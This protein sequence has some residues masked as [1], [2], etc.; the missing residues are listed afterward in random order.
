MTFLSEAI[1]VLAV[2]MTLSRVSKFEVTANRLKTAVELEFEG[3]DDL[4][5][6]LKLDQKK[7]HM[8][9]KGTFVSVQ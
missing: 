8:R 3:I 2:Q 6:H 1:R 5:N 4:R 7:I 9:L